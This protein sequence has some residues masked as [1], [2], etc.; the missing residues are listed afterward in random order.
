MGGRHRRIWSKL[1]RGEHIPSIPVLNRILAVL[2]EDLLIGIERQTGGTA[3]ERE[4]AP[5]PELAST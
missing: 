4:I 3:P 2:D 1:E 5:V